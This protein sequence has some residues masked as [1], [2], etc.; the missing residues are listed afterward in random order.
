MSFPR[1]LWSKRVSTEF[2]R[3]QLS[4][5]AAQWAGMPRLSQMLGLPLLNG[6]ETFLK[7]RRRMRV[8]GVA[9]KSRD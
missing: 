6:S 9:C 2:F 7:L 3:R 4:H 8:R 5:R 1:S